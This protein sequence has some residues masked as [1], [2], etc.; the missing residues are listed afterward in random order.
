MSEIE[1]EEF[2]GTAEF[3][4]RDIRGRN[5]VEQDCYQGIFY[6]VKAGKKNGVCT[7]FSRACLQLAHFEEGLVPD[8][9]FIGTDLREAWLPINALLEDID[10]E[11]I[12]GADLRAVRVVIKDEQLEGIWKK[13]PISF[14]EPLSEN[15]YMRNSN[16]MVLTEE[17]SAQI[18][19]EISAQRNFYITYGVDAGDNFDET[20]SFID[21]TGLKASPGDEN[22]FEKRGDPDPRLDYKI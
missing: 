8:T 14:A 18:I 9:K 16:G 15:D 21:P 7:D 2:L 5:F 20:L 19:A 4:G 17:K 12:E 3:T 11:N 22:T 6:G 13:L 10:P 1:E